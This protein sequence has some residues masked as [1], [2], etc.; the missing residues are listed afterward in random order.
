[1]SFRDV[2]KDTKETHELSDLNE[3]VYELSVIGEVKDFKA[4][5]EMNK[6]RIGQT[7]LTAQGESNAITVLDVTN[8]ELT[9]GMKSGSNVMLG[10]VDA[11]R[12]SQHAVL[13]TKRTLNSIK[14][15]L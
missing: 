10:I 6:K 9:V 3:G 1:M 12:K 5:I 8:S 4:V 15:Y 14:K 13:L 2:F 7:V 11:D